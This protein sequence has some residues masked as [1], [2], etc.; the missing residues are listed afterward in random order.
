[1]ARSATGVVRVPLQIKLFRDRSNH[2]RR[3]LWPR[4]PL[5][6]GGERFAVGNGAMRVSKHYLRYSPKSIR[7]V[8]RNG[9]RI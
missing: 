9:I 4:L 1:M 8:I 3:G 5:V 6:Q 7:S 2:P